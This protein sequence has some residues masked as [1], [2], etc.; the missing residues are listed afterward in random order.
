MPKNLFPIGTLCLFGLISNQTWAGPGKY[1]SYRQA[2]DN[3]TPVRTVEKLRSLVLPK[4]EARDVELTCNVVTW[5]DDS[6]G[7]DDFE[8]KRTLRLSS[9]LPNGV[10]SAESNCVRLGNAF[11]LCDNAPAINFGEVFPVDAAYVNHP[12][13][14]VTFWRPGGSDE[15]VGGDFIQYEH[16]RAVK[17]RRGELLFESNTPYHYRNFKYQRSITYQR[18]ACIKQ[19]GYEYCRDATQYTYCVAK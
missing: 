19:G 14:L 17:G 2:F 1:M 5:E 6:F 10:I 16:M 3:A 12:K 4:G 7:K 8:F 9:S 18:D 11:G 13:G 15:I